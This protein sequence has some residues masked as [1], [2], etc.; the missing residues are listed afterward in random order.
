MIRID[1][2]SLECDLAETYHIFDMRELSPR[3]IALFAVG[4]RDNSRIKTKI[5]GVSVD[6]NTLIDA[7]ISDKLSLIIKMLSGPE[8]PEPVLLTNELLG[9]ENEKSSFGFDS[10]A[11]FM[12][13]RNSL[14]NKLEGE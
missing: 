13:Y 8:A 14:I 7:S 9:S 2:D 1:S 10:G 12:E 11:D 6:F 5:S 3:R 4:L